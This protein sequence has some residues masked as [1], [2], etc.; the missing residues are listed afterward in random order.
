MD[1]RG[2]FK[3]FRDRKKKGGFETNEI[4]INLAK[5]LKNKIFKFEINKFK[6]SIND[7]Q[8]NTLSMILMK[9]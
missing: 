1:Q 5:K 6:N 4:L 2:Y 9:F 3:S 7:K 8:F